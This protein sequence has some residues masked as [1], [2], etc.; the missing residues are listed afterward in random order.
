MALI[1]VASVWVADLTCAI[2]V[3]SEA[4]ARPPLRL[5]A[6]LFTCCSQLPVAPQILFAY[7][8]FAL[9]VGAAAAAR[10]HHD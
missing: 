2:F 6:M 9:S 1:W 7:A 8:S 3:C 5:V 10:C 4:L